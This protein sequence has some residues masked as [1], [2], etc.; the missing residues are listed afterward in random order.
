M[1]AIALKMIDLFAQVVLINI[2]Y[3]KFEHIMLQFPRA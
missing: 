1:P 2:I 3:S